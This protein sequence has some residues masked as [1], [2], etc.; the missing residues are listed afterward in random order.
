M[1]REVVFRVSVAD[2]LEH[3]FRAADVAPKDRQAGVPTIPSLLG[4]AAAQSPSGVKKAVEVE[5]PG[6]MTFQRVAP[7]HAPLGALLE[8]SYPLPE[9]RDRGLTR[10]RM[11]IREPREVIPLV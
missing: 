1:L 4:R 3:V 7:A 6:Q 10:D 9:S 11:G 2:R 5:S 8:A